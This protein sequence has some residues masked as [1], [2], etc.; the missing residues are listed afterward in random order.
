MNIFFFFWC[1]EAAAMA[2]ALLVHRFVRSSALVVAC[3]ASHRNHSTLSNG[4][5]NF[6]HIWF[7]M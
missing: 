1:D 2:V 4:L 3:H 5:L 7:P 6:I